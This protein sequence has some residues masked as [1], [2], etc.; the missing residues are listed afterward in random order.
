MKKHSKFILLILIVALVSVLALG[1]SCEETMPAEEPGETE[2]TGDEVPAIP[3]ERK[4]SYVLYLKYADKP[5]LSAERFQKTL[6]SDDLRTPMEVA[7]DELMNYE[8]DGA[9][10]SPIPEGT[11]LLSLT[12]GEK[13]VEVDFSKEFLGVKMP[14]EDAKV[15]VAAI[16]NTLLF[17]QETAESVEI[18]VEGELLKEFSGYSFEPP[19]GFF[20]EGIFPDK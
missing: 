6:S 7:L 3:E 14:K 18:K 16:V 11:K 10:V 12:A 19:L 13:T 4:I 15:I 17:N 1:C 20:E 2:E 5:F 8:G 9:F